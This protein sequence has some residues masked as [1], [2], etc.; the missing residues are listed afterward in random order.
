[1]RKPV[2]T[3]FYQFNPWQTSIGGIQTLINTFIKYAPS[4]FEVR[5]VGTASDS[6]QSLGKWQ[7]AEFAG[8]EVSFL[9]ILKLEDDNVRGLIPTT[10]RYTAALLGRSLSSDFMHF[11]RLEPS[12]AAMNWQGEKTIFIHNDIH[13]QMATV[14]DR[15]AILWRRFP[16]AYFALESILIRQ[17]S[18]IL[19]C[20]TDAA[21]FYRQRYPQLQDRVAFVKN[22]FDNEVFYSGSQPQREANRREL[23]LQMGLDPATRFI[24]FAGRLHPQKDPVLLVRAFAALNQPHTHLLIAGDGELA[25]PVRQ[26][27]EQLGLSSQVTMLG[28][29]KQKELARLH[30]LSSAFVLS[31][32]YEGL[33]LVVLEALASGTPVVTTKC[34]ETPKLLHCDSGIVCEQRTPDSIADALRR[35]LLKPQDYPVEA[36]VRTAQPY[37]ARTVVRDVYGDMLNR[38]ELKE[39]S[40]IS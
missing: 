40:V 23:A 22:S 37:A 17:F 6:S 5:L 3:I 14:A 35:I 18:Q 15:K 34:G 13:T 1:M 27:I 16:A 32:A 8:R 25:T 10:V 12:L 7:D 11:H 2:L 4:D 31:S 21:Q 19:S 39:F 29:L 20:N 36:C 24:L 9:P 30:R 38:W 28:A 33:P 26:E